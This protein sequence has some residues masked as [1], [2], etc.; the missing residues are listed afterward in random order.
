MQLLIVPSL[1]KNCLMFLQ[2][3]S[4]QTDMKSRTKKQ[5]TSMIQETNEVN[6][7]WNIQVNIQNETNT[8]GIMSTIKY[9]D[10]C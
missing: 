2:V 8:E 10:Y 4:R 5:I 6:S 3:I 1:S 9:S 7:A